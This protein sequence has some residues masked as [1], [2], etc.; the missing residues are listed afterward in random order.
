[1]NRVKLN[2]SLRLENKLLFFYS[3]IVT[4]ALFYI[5]YLY[6]NKS[7]EDI[8]KTQNYE[9]TIADLTENRDFYKEN[10]LQL[11]KSLNGM[12]EVCAELE[13]DRDYLIACNEEQ[14]YER[15]EL[16]EREELYD[17]YDYAII[18]N[19]ERT[20]LDYDQLRYLE[21]IIQ[22]SSIP[23]PDLVLAFVMTESHADHMAINPTSNARGYGQFLNSTAR[24]LW[25]KQLGNNEDDWEPELAFDPY[26]N[27]QLMVKYID[28]LY[29]RRGSIEG[30]IEGYTG[31]HSPGYFACI[32][33]YLR[34]A[35]SS[36][37]EM[38]AKY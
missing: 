21:D 36:L 7:N 11:A 28:Y 32:D 37:A 16:K 30:I 17:K 35:G 26:L 31:G 6:M 1:M 20:D 3:I 29:R 33:A 2:V 5:S 25:V 23:E 8:I 22:E 14:A 19:G 4:T 9:S 24:S 13:I 18:W 15:V 10:G 27:L 12:I 34:R 38:E